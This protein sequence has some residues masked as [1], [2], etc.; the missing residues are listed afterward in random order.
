MDA[1]LKHISIGE[2][3]VYDQELIY[4]RAIGLLASSRDIDFNDVLSYELA[5]YPPSIFTKEGK[6]RMSKSKST[7]KKTL[8]VCVSARNCITPDVIIYDV[9]ALLWTINWPTGKIEQ[10]LTT[11]KSRVQHALQ[12]ADVVLCFD[13]YYEK[14]IKTATRNERSK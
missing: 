9:S 3:K 10:I 14:S 1:K 5:A 6:L 7:L 11:F 8:Q 4:A 12:T 13:R 2:Q